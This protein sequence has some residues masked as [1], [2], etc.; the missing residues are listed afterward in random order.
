MHFFDPRCLQV[1]ILRL[2]FTF[3]LA[4][5]TDIDSNYPALQRFCSVWKCGICWC[6]D[7]GIT[8]HIEFIDSKSFV[9]KI[10][11][12]FLKLESLA[13]RSKIISKVLETVKDYCPNIDA[14]ES[15]IDPQ[16]IVCQS[17]KPT[18]ELTL[19]S[20]KDVAVAI[21]SQKPDV[22]SIFR[23]ISLKRLLQF[24]PYAY[25]DLNTLQCIHS[26]KNLAKDKKISSAFISHFATQVAEPDNQDPDQVDQ[27]CRLYRE[28]L[29]ASKALKGSSR[30]EMVQA[31][32]M[33]R[34]ETEGTYS[35]LR[36][37]LN[38]FSIFSGR[39]PLV[40]VLSKLF[41]SSYL[42]V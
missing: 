15:V 13:H 31:L 20:I 29:K 36:E 10:R 24:E 4:P 8:A 21:T 37:T 12:E 30:Q 6:N 27:S 9:V 14:V 18:S 7:D 38:K 41:T 33:W 40:S 32:E 5:A 3:A 1:L 17:L 2:V 39:N 34:S 23:S 11:S 35:C 26:E 22:K 25:L 19:F 28:I 42:H 16:E